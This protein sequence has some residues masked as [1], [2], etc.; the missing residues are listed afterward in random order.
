MS[1]CILLHWAS[2]SVGSLK[3]NMSQSGCLLLC[4]PFKST[5]CRLF[6]TLTLYIDI[7]MLCSLFVLRF[8]G[9]VKPMGSIECGQFA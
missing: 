5:T 1:P 4:T 9:P 7:Y 6:D 8:Y 3:Q 2:L